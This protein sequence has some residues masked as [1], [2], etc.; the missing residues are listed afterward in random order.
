GVQIQTLEFPGIVEFLAHRVGLRPVLIEHLQTQLAGPPFPIAV[1]ARSVSHGAFAFAG[2]AGNG[3]RCCLDFFLH[4]Y[5]PLNESKIV[6]RRSR[7]AAFRTSGTR[8]AEGISRTIREKSTRIP[9][10]F[11]SPASGTRASALHTT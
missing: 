1:A 5:A 3:R 11:A 4:P 9:A 8:A 2:S 6:G 10:V 7:N